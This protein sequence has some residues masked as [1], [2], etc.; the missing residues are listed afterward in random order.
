[1]LLGPPVL[2]LRSSFASDFQ[3]CCLADQGSPSVMNT[4]YLFSPRLC[5]FIVLN[6]DSFVNCYDTLTS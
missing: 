1:M 3:W 2:N 4:L 5:F 6:H